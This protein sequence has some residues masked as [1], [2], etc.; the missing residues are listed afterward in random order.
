MSCCHYLGVDLGVCGVALDKFATRTDV[1]THQHG[2][3]IVGFGGILDGH[4]LEHTRFRTH[5]GFP[6]LMRVHFSQTFVALCLDAVFCAVTIFLNE[7]LAVGIVI[8]VF[9]HLAFLAAIERRHG[10]M[11]RVAMC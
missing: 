6:K 9:L 5:G 8:A 2:E 3:D 10:V 1:V 4:L 7:A 11:M